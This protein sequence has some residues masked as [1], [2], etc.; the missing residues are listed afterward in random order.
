LFSHD[1]E[2]WVLRQYENFDNNNFLGLWN[3]AKS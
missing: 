1:I 2:R 3:Q